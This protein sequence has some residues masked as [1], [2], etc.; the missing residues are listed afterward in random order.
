MHEVKFTSV[1][2]WGKNGG[3]EHEDILLMETQVETKGGGFLH[4]KIR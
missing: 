4:F 2:K 1:V 3:L